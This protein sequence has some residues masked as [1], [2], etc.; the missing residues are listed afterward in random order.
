VLEGIDIERRTPFGDNPVVGAR[1][2]ETQRRILTAALGVFGEHGYHDSR[3]EQIT[4]AAGCSRPTFYQYF[5]SKEDVFR[6]LASSVGRAVV[7]MT[8][9]LGP[10]TP[11]AEGRRAVTEWMSEFADFYDV[12]APVFSAFS[13][14]VRSDTGLAGGSAVVNAG[15]GKA[16]RR[17]LDA[18]GASF[19][20]NVVAAI[21]VTMIVRANLLRR[22]G[23]GLV[24]RRRFID[25]LGGLVHRVLVGPSAGPDTPTVSRRRRPGRLAVDPPVGNGDRDHQPLTAQGHQMRQRLVDAGSVVFPERGYH[26]TRVDDVVEA[27]G[28]SHGS[29]YRYFASKED[30][31]GVIA[32]D[33]ATRMIDCMDGFPA[34]GEPGA[35][36][37]WLGEWFDVYAQ[38]GSIIALWREM[39]FSDPV[40][41]E[42]TRRVAD[43]ALGR[44]FAVLAERSDGDPLVGA[45]AFLGLI[46]TIPHHVL[47]FGYFNQEA[48]TEALV[49]IIRRGF[50][51]LD[52]GV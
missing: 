20:G 21:T 37:S 48:A 24:A 43:V 38:H 10:V 6:S 23:A 7:Q 26:E 34:D 30:L 9:R 46:E 35:L 15:F 17:H 51:G 36:R 1:G 27:A 25:S 4:V 47:A 44:L 22:G 31:F 33:A 42:L 45:M 49:A 39:E 18:D 40:V 41:E 3:V 28:A 2:A 13:S 5:S 29:F 14:A 50:L 32:T 8:E 16:L 12:H 19:D 11:D 52:A